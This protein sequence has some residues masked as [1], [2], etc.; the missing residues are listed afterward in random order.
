ML[1]T[2]F[3]ARG[4]L[5]ALRVRL[6]HVRALDDDAVSVGEVLLK[7]GGA[8][9]PEAGPPRQ[10]VK[11]PDKTSLVPIGDWQETSTPK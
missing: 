4:Q 9:A 3:P 11:A 7:P 1:F 2:F 10:N 5:G 6:G 8:A